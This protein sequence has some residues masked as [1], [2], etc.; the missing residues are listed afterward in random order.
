MTHYTATYQPAHSRWELRTPAS[1][2]AVAYNAGLHPGD[3]AGA[4]QWVMQA[5]TD[6]DTAPAYVGATGGATPTVHASTP[7]TT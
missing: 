6:F 5:V 7:T 4:R 1:L 2:I 3:T